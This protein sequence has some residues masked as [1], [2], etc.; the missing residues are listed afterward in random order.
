MRLYLA[1]SWRNQRYETVK[2]TFEAQGH[3]VYDFKQ[4]GFA[5]EQVGLD[6]ETAGPEQLVAALNHPRAVEGFE[7]DARH[8][9]NADALVLLLPCGRSAHLEAGYALG[10]RIPVAILLSEHDYKPELMYSWADLITLELPKVIS[11][12]NRLALDDSGE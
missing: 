3:F 5:W 1:T 11:W 10:R 12:V 2:A 7:R 8:V 4:E 9:E 6:P